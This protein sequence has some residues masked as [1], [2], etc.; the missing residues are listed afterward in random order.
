MKQFNSNQQK[1]LSQYGKQASGTY[2]KLY[3]TGIEKAKNEADQIIAEAQKKADK[4]IADANAEAVSIINNTKKESTELQ[5][6]IESELKLSSKQVISSIKNQIT[7]LVTQDLIL[8]DIDKSLSDK[9]FIKTI[10]ELMVKKWQP[11]DAESTDLQIIL[12]RQGKRE[13]Q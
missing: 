8:N 4:I 3:T 5:L 1:N 2:P 12:P 11:D 9:D 10:I 13:F 7:N 6:K